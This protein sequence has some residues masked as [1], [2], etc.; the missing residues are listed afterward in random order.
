MISRHV[1][2][3]LKLVSNALL[4]VINPFIVVQ[5]ADENIKVV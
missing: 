1:F 4:S 2:I 5:N 3:A